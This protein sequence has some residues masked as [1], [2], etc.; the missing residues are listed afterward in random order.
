MNRDQVDHNEYK[1]DIEASAD[2]RA[3]HD[4]RASLAITRGFSKALE[5]SFGEL[6]QT[7]EHIISDCDTS[8]YADVIK[9]ISELEADCGFCLS[10][11]ERSLDQ[12]GVRIEAGTPA[13]SIVDRRAP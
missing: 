12:L 6:C 9:R 10:R 2:A 1:E 4:I 8:A 5:S 13:R 3:R 11:I 7:V